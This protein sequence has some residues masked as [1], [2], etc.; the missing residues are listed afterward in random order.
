MSRR[1]VDFGSI[2]R[3]P[4]G[5]WQAR[6]RNPDGQVR[7]AARTFTTRADASAYLAQLRTDLRRGE[8]ADPMAGR[9]SLNEYAAGWLDQRRVRGEP[10][11]PRTKIL[12][13]GLLTQ[14]ILPALGNVELRHLDTATVRKWHRRMAGSAGPGPNT[15]AKSYRLLHAICATA[16]A[17]EEIRRNPCVLPPRAYASSAALTC[18]ASRS[19]AA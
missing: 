16:V 12:Y 18:T 17:E 5:R 8:W 11:A 1:R 7:A 4:S 2:R 10:L 15:V 9:V 19:G 14:H 13:S 6:H 3:L